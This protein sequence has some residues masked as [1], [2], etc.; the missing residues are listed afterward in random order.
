MKGPH[1]DKLVWLLR[2]EFKVNLLNQISDGGHHSETI[3]F[4]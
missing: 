2:G 4:E 1:D 3:D